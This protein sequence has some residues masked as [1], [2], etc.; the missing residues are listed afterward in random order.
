MSVNLDGSFPPGAAGSVSG[1]AQLQ[2][3][4]GNVQF[5]ILIRAVENDS[6]SKVLA[7]PR[8]M[9]ID[10][11][12]AEVRMARD[13]PFTETSIDSDSGRVI[14]NVR[15]LQV[16]TILRVRPIVKD[17]GLIELTVSLDVSNLVE[18]RNGTPVVDR[19]TATTTVLVKDGHHLLI[20]GL[21]V[22]RNISSVDKVPLLGDIPL[23]GLLFQRKHKEVVDNELILLLQPKIV[24][25]DEPTGELPAGNWQTEY[26][27]AWPQTK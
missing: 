10:G 6:R 9:V 15:F 3:L 27:K 16:G 26:S 24:A 18:I 8:I 13:E 5:D 22:K 4:S 19:N 7:S 20:G 17:D 14:E 11:Q 2:R 1:S 21:R 23:L 12:E 25:P